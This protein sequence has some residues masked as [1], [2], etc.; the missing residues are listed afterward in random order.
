M[1]LGVDGGSEAGIDL[2][3]ARCDDILEQRRSRVAAPI[4][5]T[6]WGSMA[7]VA[8][9]ASAG[10][11]R[12]QRRY[13]EIDAAR[14]LAVI[15]M[16]FFHLMWD[17]SYFRVTD[18]NVFSRE[19]QVFARSIGATFTL[20]LGLSLAL[21]REREQIAGLKGW[22]PFLRRGLWVFGFGMLVT[23]ATYVTIGAGFVVFGILHLQ[24]L[25]L[26][27]AYPFVR[28][29][30]SVTGLAALS[31]FAL[32]SYLNTLVAPFP[33]LIW[34]GVPEQSRA[35]VDYYPLLPWFGAALLGVMVAKLLYPSGVREFNLPAV[36]DMGSI[37]L[38]RFLGRHSLVI[39]LV[40]QP[41]LI[42][43]LIALGFG[44]L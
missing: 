23:L 32:G 44:S 24:G 36:E 18:V 28:L 15:L 16:V 19:W 43:A 31:V 13:W 20:L 8:H 34:L 30:A 6:G 29:P 1:G 9:Q 26:I 17:L 33:W 12:E 2:T 4:K 25:A 37:Q 11:A 22:L 42:A 5:Q 21:R 40:H 10:E 38:L 39:Y 35:M 3:L 14:G 41:L 7:A 27:L